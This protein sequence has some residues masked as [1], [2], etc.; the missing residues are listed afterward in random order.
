MAQ[1]IFHYFLRLYR[2][3]AILN[4]RQVIFMLFPGRKRVIKKSVNAI[5]DVK[6][7]KTRLHYQVIALLLQICFIVATIGMFMMS[8]SQ[9]QWFALL[10][11]LVIVIACEVVS[12][13]D[14]ALF[15]I[16]KHNTYSYVNLS[17]FIIN[18]IFF[19]CV[20]YYSTWGTVIGLSLYAVLF[21]FRILNLIL[22]II[23]IRKEA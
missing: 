16:S 13:F 14:I 19:M 23:D 5:N 9:E 10:S 11:T 3:Y 2:F 8:S 21:I 4:L 18:A 6:T 15:I 20:I 1:A 7:M 22:N 17:L 12:A